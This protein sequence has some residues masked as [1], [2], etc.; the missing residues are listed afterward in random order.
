MAVCYELG[1]FWEGVSGPFWIQLVGIG[2]QKHSHCCLLAA[3][4]TNLWSLSLL[5]SQS[6]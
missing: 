5:W 1:Q 6:L 4:F 3:A 2:A